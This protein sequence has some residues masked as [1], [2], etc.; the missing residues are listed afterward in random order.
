MLTVVA[1]PILFA[2]MAVLDDRSE[3]LALIEHLGGRWYVD[4]DKPGNPVVSVA[5]SKAGQNGEGL[6][7]LREFPKLR[8]LDLKD[9]EDAD[10]QLVHLKSLNQIREI[11]LDRS[12]LTDA[13]MKHLQGLV[14]LRP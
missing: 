9:L 13:G 5:L 2:A 10:K 11:N 7:C 6:K 4:R 14:G 8:E 12:S 1:A 3:A